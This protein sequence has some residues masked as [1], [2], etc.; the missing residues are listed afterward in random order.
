MGGLLLGVIAMF[1][2]G[3]AKQLPLWSTLDALAPGL[4]VLLITVSLADFLAGP[5]LGEVT[6]LPIGIDVFGTRRHVVQLYEMA[7][8]GLALWTWWRVTSAAPST[9]S[10]ESRFAGRP[11]LI[12]FIVYT[13][14]RMLADSLRANTQL[15]EGYHSLQLITLAVA[16]ILLIQLARKTVANNPTSR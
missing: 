12:T 5:G 1:F 2:Y 3:R 15:I 6:E 4:I 8:G 13:I 10:A 7:V 9:S 16:L 14:G 11:F